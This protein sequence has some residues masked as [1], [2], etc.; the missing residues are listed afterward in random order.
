MVINSINL[1]PEPF[2]CYYDGHFIQPIIVI[3]G[4]VVRSQFVLME[5]EINPLQPKTSYLLRNFTYSIKF[6]VRAR[7]GENISYLKIC[8]VVAHPYSRWIPFIP[9][10][11]TPP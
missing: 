8:G 6:V 5:S 2:D 11:V 4:S 10:H 7:I 9:G 3:V 1:P